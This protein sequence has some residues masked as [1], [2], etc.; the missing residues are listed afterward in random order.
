MKTK[1][2]A[3]VSRVLLLCAILLCVALALGCDKGGQ[4][5]PGPAAADSVALPDLATPPDSTNQGGQ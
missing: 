3:P 4:P 5:K 2:G 1:G